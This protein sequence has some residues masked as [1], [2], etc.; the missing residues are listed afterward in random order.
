MAMIQ[1]AEFMPDQPD[2]ADATNIAHNVVAL[3]AESYGP[4]SALGRYTS[5][6][7]P[8]ACI[9]LFS[10]QNVDETVYLFA[11]TQSALFD[12][13]AAT[14]AWGNISVA[15]GYSAESD[16]NWRF[17]QFNELVLATDFVDPIQTFSM[18]ASAAFTE[19]SAA[20]PQ[21]KFIAVAKTF[22]IV[23]NTADPV[24][25]TNPARLWW[26]SAGD[27][28]TWPAPG[29]T[30]AQEDQSDYT[31]L[32]GPLGDI[33]GLVPNL[34]GCDCAVFFQRGIFRMLYVGP[35]DIFDLFPAENVRGTRASNSIVPLGNLVY[36]L[37]DDGFYAFDGNTSSPI[38][39]TKIDEW[40]FARVNQAFLSNVVGAADISS[41]TI[42]W[43]YPSNQSINGV[44]DS[45]L[46]YRWDLERWSDS[47]LNATATPGAQFLTRGLTF[48]ITMD[49]MASLGFTDV[50]TLPYSLDSAK[51]LGAVPNLA[52]VDDAGYLAYA[53]TT[54]LA[55]QIG[56]KATQIVPN[57]RAYVQSV[58]PLVDGG[59]P[60]VALS[61]RVNYF[62]PEVFGPDIALNVAGE[63]PQR[64]DGRYHRARVTVPAGAIWGK[65]TGVDATAIA[66]GTR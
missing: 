2:L 21:A 33:T 38:G 3:T 35:P 52:F 18:G 62:D 1:F 24:G 5:S 27:P 17:A 48:N 63:C 10:C 7:L 26:S 46:I 16:G 58:R 20:A 23:G 37:G 57:R 31:D 29:G 30:T 64:S 40:F 4:V 60:T 51:W 12:I 59:A 49:S 36:Y 15:G 61:A 28:T 34:A 14:L 44:P 6:P 25:G 45:R 39:A 66:A 47:D 32:L 22:C 13:K 8:S 42:T 54:A 56:T 9:G 41:K 43:I 55:A 65:A 11:G 53:G 50:D 19:L